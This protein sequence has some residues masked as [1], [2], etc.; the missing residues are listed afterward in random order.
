M[1]NLTNIDPALPVECLSVERDLKVDPSL[2]LRPRHDA[3]GPVLVED[4]ALRV[5][6]VE[7][8]GH[9]GA[10]LEAGTGQ[11]DHGPAQHVAVLRGEG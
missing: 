8:A 7:P 6:G 10:R 4:D 1:Y 9:A 3:G 2:G 5:L 11:V